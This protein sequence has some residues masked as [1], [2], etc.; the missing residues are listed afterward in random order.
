MK[1]LLVTEPIVASNTEHGYL[2]SGVQTNPLSREWLMNNFIHQVLHG[3]N[4]SPGMNFYPIVNHATCPCIDYLRI[5]RELIKEKWA[6]V[7]DFLIEN[8]DK[9]YYTI[10]H[11]DWFYVLDSAVYRRAHHRHPLLVYGYNK[12]MQRFYVGDFDKNLK[13]KF[14][15]ISFKEVEEGFISDENT[16]RKTFVN[17]RYL[18]M[19]DVILYKNRSYMDYKFNIDMLQH[20]ITDYLNSTNVSNVYAQGDYCY[21]SSAVFGIDS[22]RTMKRIVKEGFLNIENY[23]INYK[24]ATVPLERTHLMVERVKYLR[25]IQNIHIEP[26]LLDKMDKLYFMYDIFKNMVIKYNLLSDKKDIL[27]RIE[28]KIQSIIEIEEEFYSEFL[29]NLVV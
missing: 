8:I 3:I 7:I 20:S 26:Y 6:T 25:E 1:K 2:L 11:L 14:K 15:E 12:D 5:S 4:L 23:R 10:I 27:Y 18:Y 22:L 13:F 21:F 24:F 9:E 16:R 19:E 17:E 28:E 29:K